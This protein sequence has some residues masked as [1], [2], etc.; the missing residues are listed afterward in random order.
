MTKS[1][2]DPQQTAGKSIQYLH[3]ALQPVHSFLPI[4]AGTSAQDQKEEEGGKKKVK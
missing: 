3:C 1:K 4:L 2:S